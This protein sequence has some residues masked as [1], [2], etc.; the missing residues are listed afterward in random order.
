MENDLFNF[1][2]YDYLLCYASFGRLPNNYKSNK[3]SEL[4]EDSLRFLLALKLAG[5]LRFE[6]PNGTMRF[7]VSIP[8]SDNY[9]R[10]VVY[11]AIGEYLGVTSKRGRVFII[12]SKCLPFLGTFFGLKKLNDSQI[13]QLLISYFDLQ[14]LEYWQIHNG[15]STQRILCTGDLDDYTVKLLISKIKKLTNLN[16]VI[17]SIKGINYIHY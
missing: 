2:E 6:Y 17:K 9:S 16:P 1:L 10:E 14:V 4:S 13:I 12:R 11:L 3:Y 5:Y 8:L 7:I 15:D